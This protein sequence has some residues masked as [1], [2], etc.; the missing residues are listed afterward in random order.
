MKSHIRNST[1]HFFWDNVIAR[2]HIGLVLTIHLTWPHLTFALPHYHASKETRVDIYGRSC[3][4]QSIFFHCYYLFHC[5]SLWGWLREFPTIG[6]T[7]HFWPWRNKMF[8]TA[9][10]ISLVVISFLIITLFSSVA[11]MVIVSGIWCGP[12]RNDTVYSLS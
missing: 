10:A 6:T 7:C 4:T 8:V 2:S 9:D 1:N 3:C 11:I 5:Y 12:L